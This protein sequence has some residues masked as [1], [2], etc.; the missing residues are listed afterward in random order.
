MKKM[1]R[2]RKRARERER[3]SDRVTNKLWFET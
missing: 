1:K 2:E 3:W